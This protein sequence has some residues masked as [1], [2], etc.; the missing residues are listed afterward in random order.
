MKAYSLAKHCIY[1]CLL[2]ILAGCIRKTQVPVV[3]PT[4]TDAVASRTPSMIPTLSMTPASTHTV[5][6]TPSPGAPASSSPIPS[7]LSPLPAEQA[8]RLAIALLDD[9]AGCQLPCWWGI[10]PGQTSWQDA[11]KFFS[12]FSIDIVKRPPGLVAEVRPITIDDSLGWYLYQSLV[13]RDDGYYIEIYP[14]QKWHKYRLSQFLLAYGPPDEVWI[15]TLRYPG[16]PSGGSGPGSFMLLYL[17]YRQGITAVFGSPVER[18]DATEVLLRGCFFGGPDTLFLWPSQ[19]YQS[20]LDF[21]KAV[22]LDE[23]KHEEKLLL[24]LDAAT[25][26]DVNAFYDIY[27]N[28]GNQP[29]LDTP[30]NLWPE[31]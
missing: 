2:F 12:Q 30:E 25:D 10:T 14:L 4:R 9:N 13:Q 3:S 11:L 1:F 23:L 24:P 22:E 19:G 20:F 31:P 5:T 8:Q 27:S 18:V 16:P 28:T 29:C 7:L 21:A 26:M 15:H 6:V 17:Y